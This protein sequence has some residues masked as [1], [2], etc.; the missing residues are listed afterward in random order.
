MTNIQKNKW[1]SIVSHYTVHHIRVNHI[2]GSLKHVYGSCELRRWPAKNWLSLYI[3]TFVWNVGWPGSTLTSAASFSKFRMPASCGNNWKCLLQPSLGSWFCPTGQKCF[4]WKPEF[5]SNRF[6]HITFSSAALWEDSNTSTSF[7]RPSCSNSGILSKSCSF[8]FEGFRKA[9]Y[10]LES[11]WE[12]RHVISAQFAVYKLV[13]LSP[14]CSTP[15]IVWRQAFLF[16]C[17]DVGICV[18]FLWRSENSL[19]NTTIAVREVIASS[20]TFVFNRPNLQILFFTIFEP[21]LTIFTI[22][23]ASRS[24]IDCIVSA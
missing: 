11:T 9:V 8:V 4:F 21:Q 22:P 19:K 14:R 17:S 23:R 3:N 5:W 15:A 12:Y 16:T 18:I 7:V 6:H 1:N 20:F 2:M 13:M 10:I 24:E